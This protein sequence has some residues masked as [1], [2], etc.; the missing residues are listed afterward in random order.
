VAVARVTVADDI[1]D[2]AGEAHEHGWESDPFFLVVSEHPDLAAAAL[3]DAGVRF[4]NIDETGRELEDWEREHSEAYTP[5]YVSDVFLTTEGPVM[6]VDVKGWLSRPMGRTMVDVLVEELLGRGLDARVT[7]PAPATR[8]DLYSNPRYRP[9]S[10]TA[11]SETPAVEDPPA[12]PVREAW[13]VLLPVAAKTSK[14]ESYWDA[15]WRAADGSWVPH[16]MDAERFE[17]MDSGSWPAPPRLLELVTELRAQ[18]RSPEF[19]EISGVLLADDRDDPWPM[20]PPPV[21]R[22]PQARSADGWVSDT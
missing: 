5:N 22:R 10:T 8:S 6:T 16:R 3:I 18:P 20:P 4:M 14:E 9:G 11:P 13:Y 1:F 17:T 21:R 7:A 12:A 15:L 2:R 19:G